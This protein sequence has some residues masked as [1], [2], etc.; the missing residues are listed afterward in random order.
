[1]GNFFRM[2]IPWANVWNIII[3]TLD[4][5]V[6]VGFWIAYRKTKSRNLLTSMP[7][8][9]TSLGIL[10]TFCA[11]CY[12]LAGISKQDSAPVTYLA[13]SNSKEAAEWKDSN[14]DKSLYIKWVESGTSTFIEEGS[15]IG[16]LEDST[17]V[18]DAQNDD[19]RYY[20][21][22]E[23]T[24]HIEQNR[25]KKVSE[26]STITNLDIKQIISN[27]IPAFS[28]SIYGLIF[29]L[30]ATIFAKLRFAKEDSKLVKSLKYTDPEKALEALD[31][32]LIDLTKTTE[33][34]NNKLNESIVAQSAILSTFVDNFMD[35]MKGTFD[36]MNT[37]IEKRVTDFGTTQYLQSRKILEDLTKKLGDDSQVILNN[38]KDA[39][40]TMTEASL[41][42]SSL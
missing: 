31:E 36:A 13:F 11:I 3:F 29:A 30:L 39:V 27:L 20:R 8:L 15:I 19:L 5:L 24:P 2:L 38:M 42:S 14:P 10:G 1:M 17:F 25:A 34:N 7:G 26:A 35:K 28:T 32:H 6:F 16:S 21:L 23:N 33:T 4:L 40:K 37:S 41:T 9:F 12:S 22:N 18:F